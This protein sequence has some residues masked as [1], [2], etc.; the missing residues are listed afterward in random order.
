VHAAELAPEVAEDSD[1]DRYFT[2]VAATWSAGM[3]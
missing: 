1:G 2:R 3:N